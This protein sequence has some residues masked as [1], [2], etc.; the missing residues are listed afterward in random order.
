MLAAPEKGL[1]EIAMVSE[2][3]AAKIRLRLINLL[4]LRMADGEYSEI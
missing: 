4:L 1:G 2:L 3:N